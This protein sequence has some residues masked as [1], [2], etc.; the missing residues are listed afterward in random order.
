MRR[1]MLNTFSPVEVAASFNS[2]RATRRTSS[3]SMPSMTSDERLASTV[4]YRPTIRRATS[5]SAARIDRPAFSSSST[6]RSAMRRAG[7]SAATSTLRRRTMPR[8][9]THRGGGGGKPG[10][11]GGG[12]E[13]GGGGG[14]AGLL[15]RVHQLA[16]RL[17]VVDPAQ[18][19]PDRPEVLDVVDQR[20]P[21]QGHQQGPRD[22]G[23]DALGELQHV[24][25]T[26]G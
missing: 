9:T 15:Q 21:G 7:M 16:E 13:A 6:G 25:R 18:E 24:L 14:Q 8:A 11:G 5:C 19:L 23:P 3:R 22:A 17:R 12:V 2:A 4:S 10:A 20:G 26:L 1:T